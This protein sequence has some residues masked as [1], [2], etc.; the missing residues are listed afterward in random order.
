MKIAPTSL[1]LLT[2]A[3]VALAQQPG[4]NVNVVSHDPFNQKQVEVAA[5]ANPQNPNHVVAGFIDYQTV[6]NENPAL[7]PTSSA[8]CGYSFS[9][10]GGKTWKNLLVPGFP[11]DTSP[12][13]TSSPI[14]GSNRCGDPAIT[15]DT[16]GHVFYM[17]GAQLPTGP[18]TLFVAR[19]TDPDDGSGNL[20]YDTAVAISSGN[21]STLGQVPDK[22]SL[23]F[24]PDPTPGGSPSLPGTLYAC[25]TIFNGT[26]GGKF[27]NKVVCGLSTDGGLAYS[28]INRSEE[29]RVGKECRS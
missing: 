7:D 9:T 26:V 11:G 18:T 25:G 24:V 16:N 21:P 5:A 23:A 15:W 20:I 14:F 27:R 29:R 10:N 4:P 13:G 22:P 3:A 19:F 6:A 28:A 1:L 2:F 8:W 12:G 17:G